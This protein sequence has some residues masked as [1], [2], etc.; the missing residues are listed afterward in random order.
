MFPSFNCPS[1][2]S[3]YFTVPACLPPSLAKGTH[4]FCQHWHLCYPYTTSCKHDIP[5]TAE[6]WGWG[7]SFWIQRKRSFV[8]LLSTL[9]S[10]ITRDCGLYLFLRRD[11][12]SSRSLV[13]K[14]DVETSFFFF[15]YVI[16]NSFQNYRQVRILVFLISHLSGQWLL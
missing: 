15:F 14:W 7:A 2:Y 6:P 8:K 9:S 13:C 3:S 16:K 4:L 10:F 12:L 5:D 11:F 1:E